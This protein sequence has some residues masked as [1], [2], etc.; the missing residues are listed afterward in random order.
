MARRNDLD[1]CADILRV[2]RKGAN[3]T[4]IVYQANLN[5]KIVE[6][7]LQRLLG[8][9]LLQYTRD[10]HYITTEKGVDF[11]KQFTATIAPLTEEARAPTFSMVSS[12]QSTW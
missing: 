6:K 4:R 5:F 9:R 10:Q 8:S 12:K 11:L 2:A 1:I 7:Y 3:K